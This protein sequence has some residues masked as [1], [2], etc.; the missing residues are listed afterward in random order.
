MYL[1]AVPVYCSIITANRNKSTIFIT[2]LVKEIKCENICTATEARFLPN[3][4][5]KADRLTP[6]SRQTQTTP[7]PTIGAT[8][9]WFASL[10]SRVA[11]VRT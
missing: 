9:A 2:F 6:D 3:A 7:A 11:T 1:T 8:I 5:T 4:P 10:A